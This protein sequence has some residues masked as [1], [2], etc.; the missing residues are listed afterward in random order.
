MV[1]L[2]KTFLESGRLV[3]N[4]SILW[5]DTAGCI[6]QYMCDLAIY[7]MTFFSSSYGIMMDGANNAP[8]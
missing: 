7:V 8:S 6:K 4:M 3:S 5:E 2:L 1:D